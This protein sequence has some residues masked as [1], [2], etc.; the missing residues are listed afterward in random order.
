MKKD[1]DLL[2]YKRGSQV[3]KW[4]FYTFAS[5][6]ALSAFT[7]VLSSL[8]PLQWERNI[9]NFQSCLYYN[10]LLYMNIYSPQQVEGLLF[11]NPWKLLSLASPSAFSSFLLGKGKAIIHLCNFHILLQQIPHLTLSICGR[12]LLDL[13][14][15]P[16]SKYFNQDVSVRSCP[17]N[18]MMNKERKICLT[19]VQNIQNAH[20]NHWGLTQNTVQG[21]TFFR[22]GKLGTITYFDCFI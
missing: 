7:L 22:K 21:V 19:L 1:P 9:I 20:I 13:F 14:I 18:V 4:V 5:S 16:W 10:K 11:Q 6:L 8:A 12:Q 2:L 17:L 3:I 15:C